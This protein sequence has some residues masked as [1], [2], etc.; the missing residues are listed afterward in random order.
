LVDHYNSKIVA[1]SG[2]V[3]GVNKQYSTPDRFV[4]GTLRVVW[5]GQVY[6]PDDTKWGWSETS[7]QSIELINAPRTG[8]VMQAFYQDKTAAGQIGVEGV[9][10]SPF[11]PTGLLP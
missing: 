5:N 9:K 2:L 6:E 10:G 4:A 3:N 8:D 11:H 1:L 7:D